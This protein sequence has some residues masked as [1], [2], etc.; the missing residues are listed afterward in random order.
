MPRSRA[1]VRAREFNPPGH[2]RKFGSTVPRTTLAER[3]FPL[4]PQ[5]GLL[6]HRDMPRL[7]AVGRD[8]RVNALLGT[9]HFL[10]HYYQL[11]LPPVFIAWQ[12]TFGVSFAQLGLAMAVMAASTAILQTPMGFLVDRYGAR[13]FLVGGTLTMALSVAAMALATSYWQ[14][15]VLAL[16]SGC[17]NS[18]IHPADYSILSGSIDRARLGRSFAFHT[19]VGNI[20][21]A[22]APP[23]TAALTVLLGWRGA[24][25]AVG[26]VG[27]PVVLT[28]LW[29]SR[30]LV[31]QRREP[32]EH[33]ASAPSGMRMLLSRSVMMFFLFFLVSAAA[34]AGIQSWLIT[35]LHRTYAI[36]IAAASSALTGW[37]AGSICGVL[38]GGWV[39][40]RTDRHLPFV[41]ALTTGAAAVLLWVASVPMA[42][43][44]TLGVLFAGGL[45]MGASRTPRDVMVKDAAPPGQIGKVF[46]FVSSGMSL[47]GAI[48]PVPYG[49]IIDSGRPRLVLVVVA[50][51]LMASLFCAGGARLRLRRP[52]V[53][54]PAE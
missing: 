29:Q 6:Q 18:V 43:L 5:R 49:M 3:E 1:P 32:R 16:L 10:S 37:M 8:T 19:F 42:E 7:F 51:L 52:V 28:I 4:D 39:A 54:A 11:C 2:T 41:V 38:V 15:V 40:D 47:G 36:P 50:G 22:A 9:G 46:G 24:L 35:I 23:A 21:F 27:V 53:A 13:K 12:K 26:L 33:A 31:D 14:I 44:T 45:M 20:G 25:L 17:G 30:I 48:M 34:G